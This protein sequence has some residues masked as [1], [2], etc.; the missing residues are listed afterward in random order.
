MEIFRQGLAEGN[1]RVAI[2]LHALGELRDVVE[3][4]ASPIQIEV[5]RRLPC[6]VLR[7]DVPRADLGLQGE[8]ERPVG[9]R[10]HG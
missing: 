5:V 6:A 1:D 8:S 9:T 10:H 4:V 2:A 3:V 7:A